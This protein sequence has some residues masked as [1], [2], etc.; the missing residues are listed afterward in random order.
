MWISKK[1]I[2][3]LE[4][5]AKYWK[6]K[7]EEK[8]IQIY[9]LERKITD[10]KKD[11]RSLETKLAACTVTY[12]TELILRCGKSIVSHIASTKGANH[13]GEIA[14]KNFLKDN[15]DFS[16]MDITTVLIAEVPKNEIL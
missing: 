14:V 5:D 9:S 2:N 4:F 15:K 16:A 10:L 1:K 12:R 13:V 6:E 8:T 3:D 7:S 11:I